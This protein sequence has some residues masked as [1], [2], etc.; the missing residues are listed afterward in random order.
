[1]EDNIVMK[2]HSSVIQKL[3]R[4]YELNGGRR[5]E[6]KLQEELQNLNLGVYQQKQN[7]KQ[8]QFIVLEED[9]KPKPK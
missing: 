3:L 6:K 8:N 7:P 2:L 5:D 4:I 9:L 1:M